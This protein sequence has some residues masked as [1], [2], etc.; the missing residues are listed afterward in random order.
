MHGSMGGGWKR[1]AVCVTAPVLDPTIL[2]GG[3][4]ATEGL[5]RL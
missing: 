4:S 3:N 2:P 1:N 5:T